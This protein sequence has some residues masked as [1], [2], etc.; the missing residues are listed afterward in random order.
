VSNLRRPKSSRKAAGFGAWVFG[1]ERWL[2]GDRIRAICGICG[3]LF[4]VGGPARASGTASTIEGT[5]VS[6]FI[7][8]EVTVEFAKRPGPPTS[9]V[10]R[11]VEYRIA[12]VE[13]MRRVLDF[14]RRWFQ[15]RHRDYLIVRT[16]TGEV[17]ELYRH[18]GPGRRYWVLYKR[19]DSYP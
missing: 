12:A 18:R 11:G 5:A 7:D 2:G 8:E 19:L 16:E 13:H 14:E 4:R 15:R 6:E 10:W 9:F 3:F 17:F 1:V